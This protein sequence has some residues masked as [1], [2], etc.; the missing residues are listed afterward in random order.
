ML[1]SQG[2]VAAV[3]VAA[4][5]PAFFLPTASGQEKGG[6]KQKGK[7]EGPP[8]PMPAILRNYQPVTAERL[9]KPEDGNW[10]MIRRTYDGWGYSPLDQ[11]TPENVARLKPVWGSTTGEGRAHESAPVVNNGVLFITTPNNQ[12]IA[13][14]GTT[15]TILWRYRRPRP[16]GAIVPHEVNRGVALYGDRVYVCAGEAV[17]VALDAKTGTEV[18]STS[19]ADN[20]AGYYTTLAPL[21]AGG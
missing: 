4:L 18:W 14:D 21:I 15:G 7:Q 20:K 13:F 11:I 12:V 8:P 6:G 9:L 10:P 17:L 5:V 16:Q 1:K 2:F 19:V 3:L